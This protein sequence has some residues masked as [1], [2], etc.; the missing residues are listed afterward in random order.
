MEINRLYEHIW[1]NDSIH[2][3]MRQISVSKYPPDIPKEDLSTKSYNGRFD[4]RGIMKWQTSHSYPFVLST[5][6]SQLE[7]MI[8]GYFYLAMCTPTKCMELKLKLYNES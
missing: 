2:C 5:P 7:D 4:K 3:H 1:C 6:L 8:T